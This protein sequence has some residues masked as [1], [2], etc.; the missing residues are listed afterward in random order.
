MK[1]ASVILVLSLSV[2]AMQGVHAQPPFVCGQSMVETGVG[3]TREEV[4]EKC[5]PPSAKDSDRW[6]YRNQPGQVTVV[7]TFQIGTLEQIERIPE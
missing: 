2:F 6:Y 4:L 1:R 5:G 7:L 3:T